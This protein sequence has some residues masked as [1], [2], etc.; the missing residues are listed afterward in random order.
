MS[1]HKR[2]RFLSPNWISDLVGDRVRY[3]GG[4]PATAALRKRKALNMNQGCHICKWTAL[5][6]EVK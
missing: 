1:E 6:P 3:K 4:A 2:A 5:H